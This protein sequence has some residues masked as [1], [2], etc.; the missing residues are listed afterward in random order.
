MP[1][2]LAIS[3]GFNCPPSRFPGRYGIFVSD[4]H[5]PVAVEFRPNRAR[6]GVWPAREGNEGDRFYGFARRSLSR[7]LR[8]ARTMVLPQSFVIALAAVLSCHC[9]RSVRS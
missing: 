6:V 7:A 9:R 4:L 3:N 8:R 5:R 1:F 2:W